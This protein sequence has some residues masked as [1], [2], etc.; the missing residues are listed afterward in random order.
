LNK[1]ETQ[2]LKQIVFG[3]KHGDRA[4]AER[5][6]E[7]FVRQLTPTDRLTIRDVLADML[8]EAKGEK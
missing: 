2:R 3:L 1:A 7:R 6:F 4:L 5:D 8:A